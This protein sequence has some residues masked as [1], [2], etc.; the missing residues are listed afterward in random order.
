MVKVIGVDFSGAKDDKNTWITEAE[1]NVKTRALELRSCKSI[2]RD[3]LTERL[4]AR[5]YA[6]AA[7]D[8]PFSVPIAFAR[9]WQPDS[10]EM[11][12]L[13]YAAHKLASPKRF[14]D[15]VDQFAPA[16][17]DEILRIGDRHVPGCFSCL[18]RTRPNMVPMTFEGMRLLHTLREHGDFQVP[19]LTNPDNDSPTLLEVM[20]GAALTAF[21]LPDKGYKNGVKA[22]QLR[23]DI[24]DNLG[25]KSG[26]GLPNLDDYR[27]RC[28]KNH[29]CL[30]SVVAAVV[31]ALW[32]KDGRAFQAPSNQE[33]TSIGHPTSTRR[34]SNEALNMTE[35][36]AARLEGW[37][38]V[39]KPT[40]P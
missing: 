9:Q 36:E 28:L 34:V 20:P 16:V 15:K 39:P 27:K 25:E 11:P 21:G 35:E 22:D 24:L 26:V 5:D 10:V 31:A 37:I 38:Y 32:Y 33:V 29:D 12:D 8:F 2:K 7:M 6:V 17:A 1:L 40:A 30:D 3:N 14:R 19:P 13:W 18:H 23:Q 4:K